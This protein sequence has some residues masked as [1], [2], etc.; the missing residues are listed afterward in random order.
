MHHA[1]QTYRMH[2]LTSKQTL[3]NVDGGAGPSLRRGRLQPRVPW[4]QPPSKPNRQ[5][6]STSSMHCSAAST[7]GKK[8][9]AM[10]P[11]GL[12]LR[13]PQVTHQAPPDQPRH[14]RRN[15][16]SIRPLIL[17]SRRCLIV[18]NQR[19]PP[20]LSARPKRSLRPFRVLPQRLSRSQRQRG[21][22]VQ[23]HLIGTPARRLTPLSWNRKSADCLTRLRMKPR[24]VRWSPL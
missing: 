8:R 24:P 1:G 5:A 23:L 13:Y 10:S 16:I 7:S 14:P 12:R 15:R 20:R 22:R 4:I 3:E 17:R 9:R 11:C 18:R 19:R 2:A 6:W 21:R